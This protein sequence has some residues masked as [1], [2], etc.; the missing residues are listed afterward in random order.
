[1]VHAQE[2]AI[3]LDRVV[4]FYKRYSFAFI[5]VFVVFPRL[6]TLDDMN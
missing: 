1:M 4:C 3:V 5:L 2:M 6:Q